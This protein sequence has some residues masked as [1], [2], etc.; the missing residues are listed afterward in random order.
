MNRWVK[1]IAISLVFIESQSTFAAANNCNQ[2]VLIQNPQQV[3][4]CYIAEKE[5]IPSPAW[6]LQNS[7][8]DPDKKISINTYLLTSQI[9][10]KEGHGTLWQHTLVIYKPDTINSD[11]AL[12]FVNGGTRF[13]EAKDNPAPAQL[14]FAHIATETHSIVVDLQDVPNQYLTFPD[15]TDIPRKEDSIVAYS[16]NRFMD[17]PDNNTD[18][19]LHLPMTKAVVKAMDATQEILA[20]EAIPVN[21]FVITGA[22]K[23]GWATWLT[24]LADARVNAIVPIV[25]DILNTQKNINHIY[26]FYSN[27][28]PMPA[29]N[30][31]IQQNIPARLATP[32]FARLMQIEDPLAYLKSKDSHFYKQRLSIPKY[33]ISAGQDDFFVPDSL[34]LYVTHLPG[35]TEVRVFPQEGHY[36]NMKQAVEP[37]LLSYY[38]TIVQHETRPS[39]T[40][41]S[42]T[43]GQL[44]KVITNRQPEKIQLWEIINPNA[45]D[46]RKLTTKQLEYNTQTI[47]EGHCTI[48]HCEYLIK[49]EPLIKGW[50]TILVEATFKK[51]NGEDLVLTTPTFVRGATGISQER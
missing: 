47:E 2:Q 7:N 38:R 20:K 14:D 46:F 8:H 34:A 29:F 44:Q 3:L 15:S 4:N 30:D 42:N 45:K 51:T 26:K 13:P 28:W 43:Q 22:S 49:L 18:W 21:H 10:P 11:Q 17:D 50:E 39:L 48:H 32:A 36:I 23:R 19:P 16:W 25:I 40:W 5:N 41:I 1:L 6:V 24:A 27:H 31:Y 37:A 33:I 12:L 35:E 9:W